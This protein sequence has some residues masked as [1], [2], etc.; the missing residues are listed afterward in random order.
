MIETAENRMS[1][2]EER[3]KDPYFDSFKTQCL[4]V[5]ALFDD[6]FFFKFTGDVVRRNVQPKVSDLSYPDWIMRSATVSL[7]AAVGRLCDESGEA[8]SFVKFL[9]E[10][11]N[12]GSRYLT[13]SSYLEF[14]DD[15]SVASKRFDDLAGV[16]GK[17]YPLQKIEDDISD[18]TK[19]EPCLKILNYRHEYVAHKAKMPD[20]KLPTYDELY[21]A[22]EVISQ[23]MK[24]YELLLLARVS[25]NH[26]PTHVDDWRK[27]LTFPW[28]PGEKNE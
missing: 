1:K 15:K 10:L 2:I 4:Q 7:V 16:T 8:T 22:T 27:A 25:S 6:L 12:S 13:K 14:F 24:H 26:T 3:H 28:L 21:A 19:K 9:R 5:V 20:P 17:A 11:K 18:L 23:K